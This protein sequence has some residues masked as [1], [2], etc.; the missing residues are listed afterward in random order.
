[1]DAPA[2]SLFD[3]TALLDRAER[4]V[5]A[6][7]KAGADAADAVAVRSMS[8]GDR[9]ARRRGRGIRA[10]RRR[11]S[12]PARAGGQAPGGGLHQR[13][14]R[15]QHRDARR[16][17][18]GDGARGAGRQICRARRRKPARARHPRPRP[19]RPRTADGR[20]AG[21]AGATP[22]KQA[23]LAVQGVAKSGGASAS[24]GIG[25]MV[26]V[27]SHGFRGAYLGSRH[28]VSM[29]AIA[30]ERHRHGARLRLFLGAACLRSATSPEK[31]GRKAGERAVA[32]LNPRKVSTPQG[33]GGV[34]SARRRLAGLASRQRRQRR[35]GRA[36]DQLP[37]RQDGPEAVRRRHRHHRRSAAQAR[38][39]LASLRRRR[40]RRQEAARWSRTAC[41]AP[42]CS[43]ARPRANSASPPPAMPS[44][45]CRRCPR[46]APSN[47]HLEPGRVE[48]GRAD[49]RHQ[50][51]LLRHRPDRQRRQHGDRRLQPRRLRLLD[52]ER[53]AHLS[54]ERGHHRRPS[55][56][57]VP[58]R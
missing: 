33:A 43:T 56:R 7:R 24:A 37:A 55:P 48:P 39:A 58:Q 44:A 11:R 14:D 18:G 9:G 17:R 6:A 41:C 57:H 50:G 15:R 3:Q 49:R 35:L 53:Q 30:G 40:R 38:P 4:L 5:D 25:G 54:G 12:R 34:R 46:R 13:H 8:L 36:Q 21:R 19:D 2:K 31:I 45:A 20:Q 28:G 16:T 26:L 51:R 27:T 23:A 42:G 52:R 22:P 1:M 47:L 32:R 29:T 10:R